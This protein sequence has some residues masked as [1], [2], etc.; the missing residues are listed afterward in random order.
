MSSHLNGAKQ[1][2]NAWLALFYLLLTTAFGSLYPTSCCGFVRVLALEPQ[3]VCH[4][5]SLSPRIFRL[6]W[7]SSFEIWRD[8]G[9]CSC[10]GTTSLVDVLYRAYYFSFNVFAI[11]KL[12]YRTLSFVIDHQAFGCS[13][14]WR[15]NVWPT[16]GSLRPSSIV[17]S[18]R[19]TGLSQ[20]F[21]LQLKRCKNNPTC[22]RYCYF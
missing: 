20:S 3:N 1:L 18:I 2:E 19:W 9:I 14:Y 13:V 12:C 17:S 4:M 15:K 22:V 8:R 10:V 16:K 6:V 5:E 11:A 7:L 21:Q